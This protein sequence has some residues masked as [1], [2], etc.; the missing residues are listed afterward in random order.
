MPIYRQVPKLRH[1]PFRH[2]ASNLESSLFHNSTSHCDYITYGC[3]RYLSLPWH[4]MRFRGE[5]KDWPECESK[6]RTMLRITVLDKSDDL[7]FRLEGRLA[8][9]WVGEL[10][11]CWETTLVTHPH[12]NPRIDLAAVTFVDAAGKTFLAAKHAEGAELIASCCLMRA[13]VA[14]IAAVNSNSD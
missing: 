13:V 6:V 11:A 14:E 7:T 12:S 10:A 8:G 1:I 9:P 3:V 2:F 5:T 4:E